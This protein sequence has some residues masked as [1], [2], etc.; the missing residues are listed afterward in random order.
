MCNNNDNNNYNSS[1][2]NI[3][4]ILVEKLYQHLEERTL[5]PKEQKGCRKNARGTKVHLLINKMIIKKL[6]KK[7]DGPRDG[8][9][10]L[11]KSL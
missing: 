11:Q 8:L 10:R 1:N 9:D 4:N 5:L 7:V 2:N 3:D 6:Q